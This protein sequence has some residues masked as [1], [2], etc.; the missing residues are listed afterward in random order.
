VS[1]KSNQL[2]AELKRAGLTDGVIT[3]VDDDGV[4][5]EAGTLEAHSSNPDREVGFEEALQA[6]LD[7]ILDL[8]NHQRPKAWESTTRTTADHIPDTEF[9]MVRPL[10]ES[11]FR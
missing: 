5:I 7:D 11:D 6:L 1:R 4:K 10:D 9:R 2:L 3:T 8:P